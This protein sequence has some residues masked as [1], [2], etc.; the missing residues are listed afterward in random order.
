MIVELFKISKKK[1]YNESAR[2]GIYLLLKIQGTTSDYAISYDYQALKENFRKDFVDE[3]EE[4]KKI[5]KGDT[6]KEEEVPELEDEY[7]DFDDS[8][9]RVN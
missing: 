3:G 9:K 1:G 7:F 2:Q 6:I 5:L 4:W 8:V